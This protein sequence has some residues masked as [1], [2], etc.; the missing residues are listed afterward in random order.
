MGELWVR[1]GVRWER[2]FPYRGNPAPPPRCRRCAGREQAAHAP[3]RRHAASAGRSPRRT[4][5]DLAVR[6]LRPVRP[7]GSPPEEP[8]DARLATRRRADPRRLDRSSHGC[9][10]LHARRGPLGARHVRL[11]LRPVPATARWRRHAGNA[12]RGDHRGRA[13]PDRLEPRLG[14]RLRHAVRV[15]S[16]RRS[17]RDRRGDPVR[18]GDR[19]G[20]GPGVR[21]RR[22]PARGVVLRGRRLRHPRGRRLLDR[23]ALR[24]RLRGT[25]QPGQAL[26]GP[27]PPRRSVPP[28]RLRHHDGRRLQRRLQ[29]RSALRLRVLRSSRL[30]GRPARPGGGRRG[31]TLRLDRG[32]RLRDHGGR[33][34]HRRRGAR[35]RA[36]LRRARHRRGRTPAR[37]RSRLGAGLRHHVAGRLLR[38]G[39]LRREHRRV[40]RHGARHRAGHARCAGAGAIGRWGRG[41]A[42]RRAAPDER[43][44]AGAAARRPWRKPHQPPDG[45]GSALGR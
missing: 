2:E 6:I 9:D 17:R 43:P 33:R 26:D 1:R 45:A 14:P 22:L 18:P 39:S 12:A 15:G 38:G 36:A 32:R 3:Q 34:L 7:G 20:H 23:D 25:A 24:L 30:P 19:R 8:R 28:R 37:Q 16:R 21:E 10:R 35:P 29:Q 41:G 4:R 42:A 5:P 11:G 13:G 27:H 40:R 44:R 31:A